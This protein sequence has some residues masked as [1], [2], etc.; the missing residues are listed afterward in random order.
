MVIDP[1]YRGQGVLMAV[2]PF[3]EQRSSS[4]G[5]PGILSRGTITSRASLPTVAGGG[6]LLGVISKCVKVSFE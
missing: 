1:G 5:Y 3:L 2:F 6:H 4:L